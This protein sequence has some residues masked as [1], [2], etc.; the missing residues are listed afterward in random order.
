MDQIRDRI[1][2]SYRTEKKRIEIFQRVIISIY[3]IFT[4]S[5]CI[6]LKYIINKFIGL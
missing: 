4:R 1:K 3:D 2:R 6:E 5:I